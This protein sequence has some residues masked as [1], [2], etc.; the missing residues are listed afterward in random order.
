MMNKSYAG[1]HIQ[2]L[3]LYRT[4]ILLTVEEKPDLRQLLGGFDAE[5]NMCAHSCD[6]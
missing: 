6:P 2:H 3:K 4:D 5:K 1:P